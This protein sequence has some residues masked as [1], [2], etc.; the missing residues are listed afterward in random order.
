MRSNALL[1][2]AA[3]TIAATSLFPVGSAFAQTS[4]S[5][6]PDNSA[7]NVRDREGQT[8]TPMDQSN[9]PQDLS[10]SREIRKAL[11]NDAQLSIEAKNIKII[12]I[13]GAVTLRGPVKTEQEKAD[14]QAKAA[15]VAGGANIHNQLEVAGQ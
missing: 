8:L 12:T 14:I 9:K 13:D 15:Q 5:S 6:A 1:L 3:L 7:R 4:A 11:M 10:I 2:A